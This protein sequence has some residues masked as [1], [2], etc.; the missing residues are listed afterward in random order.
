MEEKEPGKEE[1]VRAAGNKIGE[2][3]SQKVVGGGEGL[4]SADGYIHLELSNKQRMPKT[5]IMLD[6]RASI[7]V[8]LFRAV[9]VEARPLAACRRQLQTTLSK[10]L[11]TS[12]GGSHS[13][14]MR[15]QF[16]CFIFLMLFTSESGC[17]HVIRKLKKKQLNL[18]QTP[19][20]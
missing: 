9:E 12:R 15:K 10:G 16:P 5:D 11:T 17:K 4:G 20:G 14:V 3:V 7:S 8:D 19:W 1:G 18:P 2:R 13:S 6:R